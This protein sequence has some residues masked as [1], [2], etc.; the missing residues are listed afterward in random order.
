MRPPPANSVA[1]FS[2]RGGDGRWHDVEE[3]VLEIVGDSIDEGG[4]CVLESLR[5]SV[6]VW[7]YSNYE[8]E[9]D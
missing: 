5:V 8:T 4:D 2:L 3:L 7:D 9:I 1:C 6:M